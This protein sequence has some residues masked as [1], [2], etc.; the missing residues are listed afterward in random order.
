MLKPFPG[1]CYWLLTKWL[2]PDARLLPCDAHSHPK[3]LEG[4]ILHNV[5][6]SLTASVEDRSILDFSINRLSGIAV[7]A[8]SLSPGL[9]TG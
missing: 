3:F 7:D 1:V 5:H 8:I 6:F 2:H 9:S 4:K